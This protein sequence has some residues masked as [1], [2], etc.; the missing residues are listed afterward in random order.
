MK[1]DDEAMDIVQEPF[2][3]AFDHIADLEEP[4]AFATWIARIARNES[5]MRL[6]KKRRYVQMEDEQLEQAMEL[7]ESSTPESRPDRELANQQL[8]KLLEV[9]IDE[10]PDDF[11]TVFVMRSI[12]GCSTR[13]SPGSRLVTKAH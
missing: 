5:L 7:S 9:C 10:L 11:R 12:E 4:R 8:G 6:R 3:T 2:V 13:M 1:E